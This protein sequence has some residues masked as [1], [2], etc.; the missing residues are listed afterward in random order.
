MS[1]I[2]AILSGTF[3][4][5]GFITLCTGDISDM[6]SNKSDD[7]VVL[8]PFDGLS[9]AYGSERAES[10][11]PTSTSGNQGFLADL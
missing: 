10:D 4:F 6:F 1:I 7:S 8:N 2:S 11:R 9:L 3:P 5:H